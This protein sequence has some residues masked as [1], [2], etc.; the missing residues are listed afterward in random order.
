MNAAAQQDINSAFVA[1]SKAYAGN[2]SDPYPTYA[3]LRAKCPVYEGD[4]VAELGIPSMVAGRQGNRKIFCLLGD[5]VIRQAL[6]DPD[7]FS[8]DIYEEAFGGVMGDPV[9]LYLKGDAHRK[10]RAM[11]SA[12]LSPA[13]LRDM[14]ESHFI[15]TIDGMVAELAK[16]GSAELMEDFILDFPIRVIYKLFGLPNDDP[17]GMQLFANRSLLM[18]LGG[19]IDL[20]KPEEAMERIANASQASQD[21]FDQ[22]VDTVRARRATGDLSGNDLIS[23][24]LRYEED[25][26]TLSDEDIAQSLRPNLAAA[27]ETTSRA[28][29]N[30]LACLLERPEVLE[31]VRQ[32]RSLITAVINETMRFEGSVSIVPRITAKDVEMCGVKIPAGSGIN[33]LVGSANRDPAVHNNPEEFSLE[34][35]S[36][37]GLS[38]GF[39]PHMCMGMPL[40][41]KEM[42]IA[43]NSILDR[44]PNIRLDPAAD[45]AGISGVQ[46]RSPPTLPVLWDTP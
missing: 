2:L 31:Q 13:A 19:M 23:Q 15:P 24:L 39:G 3:K 33:V 17:E 22:L 32:D 9:V 25:G 18:V 45:Y 28:F 35:R 46:F 20:S 4:L 27:G 26:K 36:K 14:S 6:L 44:M 5:E 1:L 30:I 7:T 12:V 34:K 10:Y 21:L 16:C 43:L 11:L 40:A 42:E 29:A 41:K 8:S 38:F 37:Q